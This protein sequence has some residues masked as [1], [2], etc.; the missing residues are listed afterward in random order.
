MPFIHIVPFQLLLSI[1]FEPLKEIILKTFNIQPTI[2]NQKIDISD[3]YDIKRNQYHSSK[4]LIKLNEA[5]SEG[6]VKILGITELDLF[7]PIL[8]FVFGEAQLNG[9]ASVISLFRLKNQFYGLPEDNKLLSERMGKEAIHELGHN[10][11]LFHCDNYR[12]VMKSSTYVEDVDI[13]SI[14]LCH[15]CK[16]LL[17]KSL[18]NL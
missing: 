14:D 15:L 1:D 5:K 8:T 2:S 18:K 7:I 12:C 3:T 10:F 4:I 11:G 6:A 13:K 9:T 16:E 17:L